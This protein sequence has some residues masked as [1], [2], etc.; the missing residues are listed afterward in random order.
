MLEPCQNAINYKTH[1]SEIF[2]FQTA[3]LLKAKLLENPINSSQRN[4]CFLRWQLLP[5]LYIRVILPFSVQ[6][7]NQMV[8]IKYNHV[9]SSFSSDSPMSVTGLG[10]KWGWR[11]ETQAW[12]IFT[13][14]NVNEYLKFTYYPPIFE[15]WLL[16]WILSPVHVFTHHSS[17]TNLRCHLEL[18]VTN[19]LWG[20]SVYL[21]E[22]ALGQCHAPVPPVQMP[23]LC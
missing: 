18:A 14:K 5:S 17:T 9:S 3:L 20:F 12:E 2:S 13:K 10:G 11:W 8:N 15:Y 4:K 19:S 23:V 6:R 1:R 22:I 21:Q 16:K 7:K